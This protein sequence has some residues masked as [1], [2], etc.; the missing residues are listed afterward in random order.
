MSGAGAYVGGAG[1]GW[2]IERAEGST[3]EVREYPLIPLED[4]TIAMSAWR[5]AR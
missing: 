4:V 3:I 2:E 5:G 1:T